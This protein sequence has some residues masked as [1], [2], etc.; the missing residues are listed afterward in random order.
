MSVPERN[1]IQVLK[2]TFHGYWGY[3]IALTILGILT[4]AA[5]GI[6]IASL[7]PILS[8]LLPA[9]S[10]GTGSI[11]TNVMQAVFAFA[12][13]P[14]QFRFM[15]IFVAILLVAR[16]TL[17]LLFVSL[18]G[19]ANS[20]FL[21]RTISR[22][23]QLMLEVTWPFVMREKMGHLQN[24][25][26][27]DTKRAGQLLDT[28]VQFVQSVTGFLVYLAVAVLISPMVTVVTLIAGAALLF[29]LRPVIRR[30][31]LFGE[32][33]SRL[34]KNLAQHVAE[35]IQGFKTVKAM[36]VAPTALVVARGYLDRLQTVLS[37]SVIVQSLGSILIQ[38]FSFLF[39]M[40]IF[41]FSY[42][43]GTFNLAAFAATLYLIQKIF[44]YLDSMQSS[45]SSVIQFIPFAETVLT[46]A[47]RAEAAREPAALGGKEFSFKQ[48]LTFEGVTLAYE[49]GTEALSNVSFSVAKG[50]FVGIIGP[51]GS[52]KTSVADLILR[53]FRPT[54]GRIV[55]DET[56]ADEIRIDEW[57]KHIAYVSQDSFVMHAS[58]ADNIRF[59]DS[60]ISDEDIMR[61]AQGAHIYDDIMRLPQGF[62]TVLGDRGVT[63]SGGQRQRI[64]I[65]R[66]LARKPEVL[67]FDEVTSSLDSE[68]ERLIQKVVEE[69]RGS[70]TL[71]VIAHRIST[72]LGSDTLIVLADGSIR[73]QGSPK[74]MLQ[75]PDSYLSRMMKLQG[76]DNSIG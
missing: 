29:V 72:V 28:S 61:A 71:V 39:A 49:G 62:A 76:A 17:M 63:L 18:R 57:R 58:V 26:L 35:H 2:Q 9:G 56:P 60:N 66:A 70:I 34:E 36:G 23:Y 52:G 14:F 59:Y 22:L 43:A 19:S 30:T 5:D 24:V 51:S 47:R 74:E 33:T 10:S 8:F 21:S 4:A 46:F 55:L 75:N 3:L 67:V 1:T 65:A 12:H 6:S 73:E 54:K 64:A 69:L 31:R 45:F 68:L 42:Y 11:V 32:E 38:P 25:I 37:R 15:I 53:L 40:G 48:E 50:D 44:V 7:I 13:I 41:A 16:A 20:H 27:W